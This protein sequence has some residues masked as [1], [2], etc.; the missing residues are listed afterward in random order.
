MS[1]LSEQLKFA[2]LKLCNNS[3]HQVNFI[4]AATSLLIFPIYPNLSAKVDRK[5]AEQADHN[6]S[7]ALN[8]F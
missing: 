6:R 7:H 1:G 8:I 2:S 5:T 3:S 4:K